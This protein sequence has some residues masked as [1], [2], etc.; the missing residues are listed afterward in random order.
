[1]QL[2]HFCYLASLF[3]ASALLVDL[4]EEGASSRTAADTVG[5][6]VL[7]DHQCYHQL[8][9]WYNTPCKCACPTSPNNA[10]QFC[11][12]SIPDESGIVDQSGCT[13]CSNPIEPCDN[14]RMCSDDGNQWTCP[15][16]CHGM[17]LFDGTQ[18]TNNGGN[19]DSNCAGMTAGCFNPQGVPCQ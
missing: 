7:T 9:P 8:T 5:G 18:C 2:S 19:G 4:W 1:M 6:D 3:F 10:D 15:A 16:D 11:G 12:Q 14:G 17:T 13:T